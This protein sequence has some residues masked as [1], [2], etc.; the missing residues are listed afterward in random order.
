MRVKRY[1]AN[2]MPDAMTRIRD[3]LGE[4]AIILDSK[5]IKQGGVWGLFG[6]RRIEVIAAVDQHPEKNHNVEHD[7]HD[8]LKQEIASMKQMMES[9]VYAQGSRDLPPSFLAI[10][11]EL[12]R[13]QVASDVIDSIFREVQSH[14]DDIHRVDEKVVQTW[15]AEAIKRRFAR[16]VSVTSPDSTKQEM[17]Y[18]IGPTGVGKTTTIAKIAANYV[19]DKG[20]TVGLIAADTYRIAAVKQLQTYASILNIPLEVVHDPSDMKVAKK[21]LSTCDII[22]VDTAGRNYRQ[23]MNVSELFTYV[24]KSDQATIHLVLSLTMRDEDVKAVLENVSEMPVSHL[25]LTKA[26][27]TTSYGLALNLVSKTPYQLSFVTTGQNVPDDIVE[28]DAGILT[29]WVMGGDQHV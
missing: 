24:R 26:D 16:K 18:F 12:K 21:E 6:K 10:E 19:L 3:D 9:M 13:Q 7:T 17:I 22:L 28:A 23:K 15:V 8:G 29:Q 14:I 20:C 2:S 27:E 1:V 25:L 11:T 5:P 4:R